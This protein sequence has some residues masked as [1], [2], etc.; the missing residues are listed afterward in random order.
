[1]KK[2]SRERTMRHP[3]LRWISLA[4]SILWLA[5][6]ANASDPVYACEDACYEVESSCFEGCDLTED[7]ESC[8]AGCVE[9]ASSCLETCE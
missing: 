4:G 5:A 7:T 3:T 9:Q 1:V 6:A 8:Q 2:K